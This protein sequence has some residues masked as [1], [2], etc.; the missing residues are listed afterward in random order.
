MM[1]TAAHVRSCQQATARGGFR[2]KVQGRI[3]VTYHTDLYAF[4]SRVESIGLDL[5]RLDLHSSLD[6]GCGRLL[7]MNLKP[8][9][10]QF[11]GAMIVLIVLSF[12]SSTA[13]AHGGHDHGPATVVSDGASAPVGAVAAAVLKQTIAEAGTVS[14]GKT[15]GSCIGGCCGNAQCASC[16]FVLA[17]AVPQF[18]ALNASVRVLLPDM[19]AKSGIGPQDLSRPPR[20]FV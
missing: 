19:D 20:T 18:V 17:S 13:E 1:L 7:R 11:L 10:M 4:L 3:C 2:N 15:E 5:P 16:A 12:A 8:A 6:P 14:Q 9:L